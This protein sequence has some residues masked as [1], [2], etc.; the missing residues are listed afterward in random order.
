MSLCF[1]LRIGWFSKYFGALGVQVPA[2]VLEVNFGSLHKH[3]SALTLFINQIFNL[4]NHRVVGEGKMRSS[5]KEF[6]RLRVT[7]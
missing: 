1:F 5:V 2:F 3:C 6:I 4:Q 7:G